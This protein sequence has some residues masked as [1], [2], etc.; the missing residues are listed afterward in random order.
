MTTPPC[1]YLTLLLITLIISS[2]NTTRHID[3]DYQSIHS[4]RALE[5]WSVN[6]KMSLQE[7]KH[8]RAATF[9]WQQQGE[10]FNVSINGPFGIGFIELDGQIGEVMLRNS[11]G[12]FSAP[13]SEI[14]LQQFTDLNLPV[15]FLRYWIIGL[16]E[17]TIKSRNIVYNDNGIITSFN[18]VGWQVQY[19]KHD[20]ITAKDGK[21]YYLP[22]KMKFSKG[23]LQARVL[24]K[25]WSF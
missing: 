13:T 19:M 6:G 21:Q 4:A 17:N 15:S 7:A 18:Q 1:Y 16:P 24:L 22:I 12:E 3:V 14:L 10:L 2:C 8:T 25:R 11:K 5:Q 20:L 9:F 23:N